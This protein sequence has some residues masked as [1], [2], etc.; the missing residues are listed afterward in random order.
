MCNNHL[1]N[2][3]LSFYGRANVVL[4]RARYHKQNFSLC[5]PSCNDSPEGL[6]SPVVADVADAA[7]DAVST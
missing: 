4:W 3:A 5:S 2:I 7:D 1:P 6:S